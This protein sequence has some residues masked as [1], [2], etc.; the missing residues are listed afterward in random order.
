MYIFTLEPQIQSDY[1]L[2]NWFTSTHP[3]V[4]L[5][6]T[7]IMDR[8]GRDKRHK[9]V[10]CRLT[11]EAREGVLADARTIG[12]AEEL[13]AVLDQTFKITPPVPAAEI[14]TRISS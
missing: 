5:T 11:I 6:T 1:E 4:P 13:H 12:S 2:G 7:L 14:F 8:V 10:N 9:L 3:R